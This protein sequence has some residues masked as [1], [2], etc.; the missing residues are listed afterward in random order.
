MCVGPTDPLGPR[1][2]AETATEW[3]GVWGMV[4]NNCS[5]WPWESRKEWL[6]QFKVGLSHQL[7]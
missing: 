4:D 3:V 1:M 2:R 7:K 5:F 6:L